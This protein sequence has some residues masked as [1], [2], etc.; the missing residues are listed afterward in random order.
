M[1]RVTGQIRLYGIR[2]HGPGSARAL[3][4]ALEAE[5]PDLLLVEG[6]PEAE[7]LLGIVADSRV[8]PPVALLHYVVGSPERVSYSPYAVFSPE[9]QAISYALK[10]KIPVRMVDLPLRHQLAV[11]DSDPPGGVI[12]DPLAVLA[13]AAGYDDPALWWE[14]VIEQRPADSASFATLC[15]VMAELRDATAGD[16]PELERWREAWI[17][18][19]I[20]L[21]SG[22]NPAGRIAVVCGAWHLP[23]LDVSNHLLPGELSDDRLLSGL[24][25]VEVASF[26]VPWSDQLLARNSGYGAGLSAPGWALHLWK[27]EGRNCEVEWVTRSASL[28]R[29]QGYEVSPAAVIEAVRLAT[30]L[31][32]TRQLTRPGL[33][34]LNESILATLCEGD[35]GRFAL[36]REHLAIGDGVGRL[37]D[38]VASPPLLNDWRRQCR[39]LRL[40]PQAR[41]TDIHLDLRHPLDLRR[42]RFFHQ[43]RLL[44]AG[45][46]QE[47]RS[48]RTG[49]FR[50]SWRLEWTPRVSAEL[51]YA[52]MYGPTIES[53]AVAL[54]SHRLSRLAETLAGTRAGGAEITELI[55]L[56]AHILHA[57]LG[58]AR[59]EGPNL[60]LDQLVAGHLDRLTVGQSELRRLIEA[61]PGLVRLERYGSLHQFDPTVVTTIVDLL[62]SRIAIGITFA[63][64]AAIGEDPAEPLAPLDEVDRAMSLVGRT[65]RAAAWSASLRQL[66]TPAATFAPIPGAIAGR[67]GLLLWQ[68]DELSS[69]D[70]LL[71]IERALSPAVPASEA[72][73]WIE[74]LVRPSGSILAHDQQL[75]R[76]I[77]GWLSSLAE[78]EFVRL[79]P[80]LRRAFSRLP[81]ADRDLLSRSIATDTGSAPPRATD[82]RLLEIDPARAELTIPI[83]AR[84][85]G[86]DTTSK[87]D[88]SR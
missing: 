51:N 8:E 18:R 30:A 54:V 60:R 49:D 44:G 45:W 34:E 52:G 29:A 39:A 48:A 70:L 20:R 66:F 71:G 82:N 12:R 31:A 23:A 37:P 65:S 6:P 42:S 11:R 76:V 72:A 41:R 75:L 64:L 27:S 47:Q 73:A 40:D 4:A 83:L 62:I 16:P 81:A 21:A 67:A 24:A 58:G 77:D 1:E 7:P 69:G 46:S 26:W 9:W 74:G 17:R 2:H 5:P 57:G 79:L 14:H 38:D 35:S 61:F 19:E 33:V 36:I 88:L 22:V 68:A 28:L 53:A 80:L 78:P 15:E 63:P 86:M 59:V 3:L 56:L 50:E 13:E 32:A 25:K 84:L 10:R 87:E 55:D 43:L 85:L